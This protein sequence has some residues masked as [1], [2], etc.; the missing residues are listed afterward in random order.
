MVKND[1]NDSAARVTRYASTTSSSVSDKI[2]EREAA[3]VVDV[4][5]TVLGK[6]RG[7]KVEIYMGKLI[8]GRSAANFAKPIGL[9][10]PMGS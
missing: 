6:L 3:Y 10:V 9:Y 8:S 7:T 2:V 1:A 4:T 5:I